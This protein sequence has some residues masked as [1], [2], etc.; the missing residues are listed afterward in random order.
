MMNEKSIKL[1][2]YLMQGFNIQEKLKF[3]YQDKQ[4]FKFYNNSNLLKST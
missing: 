3:K 2:K 1:G 4:S